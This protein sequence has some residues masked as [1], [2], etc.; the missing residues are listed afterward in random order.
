MTAHNKLA[1]I[2][3]LGTDSDRDGAQNANAFAQE[4]PSQHS[5]HQGCQRHQEEDLCSAPG[6]DGGRRNNLTTY[7][8]QR[9]DPVKGAQAP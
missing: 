9:R 1:V 3:V 4:R 7:H 5:R 2:L 8:R 6:L